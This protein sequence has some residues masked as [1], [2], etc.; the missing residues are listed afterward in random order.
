MW[1]HKHAAACILPL[2]GVATGIV[3]PW[4]DIHTYAGLRTRRQRGN[5]TAVLI[6]VLKFQYRAADIFHILWTAISWSVFQKNA[7]EM[8]TVV[9]KSYFIQPCH[10]WCLA[11]HCLACTYWTRCHYIITQINYMNWNMMTWA[12]IDDLINESCQWISIRVADITRLRLD[13]HSWPADWGAALPYMAA[14]Y[15]PKGGVNGKRKGA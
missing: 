13:R 8:Q 2:K 15:S 12:W 1:A 10:T 7:S 5:E 11:E 9:Y 14:S 4:A 6:Y 3:L